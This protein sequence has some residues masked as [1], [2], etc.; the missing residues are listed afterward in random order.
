MPRLI[1]NDVDES[2]HAEL[3]ERA[4]LHGRSVGEE[5]RAILRAAVVEPEGGTRARGARGSQI[6]EL[7]RDCAVDLGDVELR[8]QTVR[9]V[10][11]ER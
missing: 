10:E 5:V 7:F 1:V 3:A 11:F 8:G 9:P 2:L 6:V 4:R